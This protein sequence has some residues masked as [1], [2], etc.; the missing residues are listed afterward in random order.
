[1]RL[2]GLIGYPLSHSFSQRYFTQKFKYERI[3]DCQYQNFELA[4]LATEI[5]YLKYEKELAGLNVTI[6]YKTAILSYLDE[7]SEVVKKIGA[8]NCIA[9]KNGKW[10][11]HNTDVT[12]FENSFIPLLKPHHKKALILGTGGASQAVA[13]VLEKKGIPFLKVSRHSQPDCITYEEVDANLIH[14]YQIVINTTPVGM[15]PEV[16]QCP[17]LPYEAITANHYFFDLI[18]NPSKTLFLQLAEEKGALIENGDKMLL[19]QAEES[20]DIWNGII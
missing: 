5:L 6:P 20:W 9:I 19:I 15:H 10:V 14:D 16:N 8:C 18:Y 3:V 1:M 7:A 13:Y 17:S 11:G 2:F 4:D 12:G